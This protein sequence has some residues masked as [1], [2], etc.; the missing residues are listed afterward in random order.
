MNKYNIIL[1]DPPWFFN[2]RN[3]KNTR[4]GSGVTDK[5]PT[6]SL[7]EI[8]NLNIP[9]ICEDNCALFMWCTTSTGDSNLAEKLSLFKHWGFKL[10]NEGFTWVKLNPKS[11][12]PFFGVGHYT[13]S[14]AEHCYLGIKG[15]MKPI[16]NNVSS[17][18]ISPREE[19]SKKPD[20]VRDKIVELFGDLP[21]IELFARQK[22]EGWDYLGNDIDGIDIREVLK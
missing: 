15:K 22:F 4:F 6:M 21:R 8:S 7:E 20:I 11:K 14:N 19:H 3:N 10:V 12:T 5:Y 1:M 2:K 13:K 16:S 9:S 18:I 17:L